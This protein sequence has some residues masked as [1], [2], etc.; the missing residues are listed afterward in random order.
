[1]SWEHIFRL[2]KR[3]ESEYG[4]P[5]QEATGMKSNKFKNDGIL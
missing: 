5:H 2:Q 4:E 1:M 3:K